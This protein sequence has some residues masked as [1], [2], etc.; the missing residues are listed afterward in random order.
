MKKEIYIAP[1]AEQ[2]EFE[3]EG[4]FATTQSS[5]P[6]SV[7]TISFETAEGCDVEENW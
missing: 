6:Y 1:Q 3:T 5:S 4:C 2:L 7:G